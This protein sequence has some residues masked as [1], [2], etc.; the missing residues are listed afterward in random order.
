MEYVITSEQ[1]FE[2][3]ESRIM[4]AL[5]KKGL[6][7][8]RT[9]SLRSAVA[10]SRLGGKNPPAQQDRAAA[11][12]GPGYSVLMIY[13]SDV[14]Q[15]SLGLL[16]LYQRQGRTVITFLPAGPSEDATATDA[17]PVPATRPAADADAELVVALVLSGLDY[18]VGVEHD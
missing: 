1:R 12:A 10:T 5:Q 3:V 14:Q 11:D 4:K 16:T 17:L 7:V 15:D 13:A 2:D 9:F 6:V 8:Q 18:C